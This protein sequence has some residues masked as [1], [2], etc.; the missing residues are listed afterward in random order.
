MVIGKHQAEIR[1]IVSFGPY[2]KEQK[3]GGLKI[4]SE[5]QLRQA[6]TL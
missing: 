4:V 5:L 2:E 1:G 6:V 3:E